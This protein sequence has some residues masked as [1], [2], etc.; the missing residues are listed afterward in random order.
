MGNIRKVL[1]VTSHETDYLQDIVYSGL[2]ELLGTNAVL[3]IP[4]HRS[5]HWATKPYPKN[6]GQ[7][8]GSLWPNLLNRISDFKYDAVI[9]ASTKPDTFQK[10]LH[11]LPRIPA[12]IPVAFLDGGDRP[13]L[14][15]DLERLGA[16]EL[17]SQAQNIRP[18]DLIFKREYLETDSHPQNVLSMP[19]GMDLRSIPKTI[20]TT[21]HFAK[22]Y[23]V[24]F[25]AV[26]SDPI[27]SQALALLEPLFDCRE[28]GTTQKQV[29]RKYKRKG[30]FYLQELSHCQIVLNFRGVGWDTL[31]YWEVPAIGTFMISG[32]P[33]IRIPNNFIH[34]EEIIYCKDDL[35]DLEDLCRYYLKHQEKREKIAQRAQQKLQTYH[36]HI[37]RA[38][39]LV[40][41]LEKI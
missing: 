11:F 1:Y 27:R 23:Q 6:M 31:R 29:F 35:S 39:E 24:S 15:G 17:F 5:Y 3:E 40:A 36:S 2:V 13:E 25:W 34:N 19:F 16:K 14:G 26:E 41:A 18:F 28:N 8:P 21:S 4:F 10:Y 22:K 7:Q 12:K 33:Q 37:A 38:K 32:R 30:E 9:V 20:S